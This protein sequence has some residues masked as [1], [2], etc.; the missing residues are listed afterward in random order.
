[1]RRIWLV[2]AA[3]AMGL[4]LVGVA[5]AAAAKTKAKTTPKPVKFKVTCKSSVG[6]VPAADDNAVVPPA[7]HGSQYGSVRCGKVFGGGIQADSFKL[8]DTGDLQ[9][10]WAQYYGV[11]TIHGQFAL[12][13][14]DTGPPSSTTTFSAVTYSG[15]VTVA[16]G[17]GAY[18]KATGK[19]TMNCSSTDGVHF[20]C[21]DTVKVVLPPSRNK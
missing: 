7:D 21:S 18:K 14:A 6:T 20:A 12:T 9:G 19:G 10:S 13:P 8:L 17:T 2:V 16:G 11:G 1:L 15:T 4:L 5:S 3:M